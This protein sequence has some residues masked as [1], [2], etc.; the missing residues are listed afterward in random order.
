MA[1]WNRY[2]Q[3]RAHANGLLMPGPEPIIVSRFEIP[4]EFMFPCRPEHKVACCL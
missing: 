2:Q 1:S 3:A 4:T